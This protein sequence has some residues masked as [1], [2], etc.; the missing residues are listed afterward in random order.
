VVFLNLIGSKK[1]KTRR[2]CLAPKAI[3]QKETG[4]AGEERAGQKIATDR[5]TIT[6]GYPHQN[7]ES[8]IDD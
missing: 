6:N 5:F 7:Y 2:R 8:K 1:P 3:H 4:G